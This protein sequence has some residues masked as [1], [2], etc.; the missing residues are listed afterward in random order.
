MPRRQSGSTSSQREKEPA[1][2]QAICLT[3]YFVLTLLGVTIWRFLMPT[4]KDSQTIRLDGAHALY[5]AY[6]LILEVGI[7][8][9]NA[10]A[11]WRVVILLL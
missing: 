4:F 5:Y 11:A 2:F 3:V 6:R 8:L 9:I 7:T 10:A 1:S